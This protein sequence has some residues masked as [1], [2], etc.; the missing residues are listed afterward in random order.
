MLLLLRSPHGHRSPDDG[1]GSP[2]RYTPHHHYYPHHSQPYNNH[3]EIGFSD[4]VSNVVEMV[5]QEHYRSHRH[6]HIRGRGRILPSPVLNGFKPNPM[7]EPFKRSRHS[8]SDEDDW[9]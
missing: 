2:C 5:K 4:T 7:P 8:D 9:C 3:H 1:G 6:P